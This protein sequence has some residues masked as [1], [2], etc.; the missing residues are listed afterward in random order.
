MVSIRFC[1][2]TPPR[3][4]GLYTTKMQCHSSVFLLNHVRASPMTSFPPVKRVLKGTKQMKVRLRKL[5]LIEWNKISPQF[6]DC[7]TDEQACVCLCVSILNDD[8]FGVIM[9]KNR[10][11]YIFFTDSGCKP[12]I[13]LCDQ[14]QYVI[15]LP[16]SSDDRC[17][18]R[19]TR[20]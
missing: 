8:V 12:L 10:H 11:T 7:F 6:C 4:Q 19:D 3:I 15:L 9:A 13:L 17:D 1:D 20:A 5:R 16:V 2:F 18:W 14:H